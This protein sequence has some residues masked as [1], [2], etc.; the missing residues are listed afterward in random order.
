MTGFDP[1][2]M[3]EG[4]A[5][6]TE[7]ILEL[8][9]M[10]RAAALAKL[11]TLVE[12]KVGPGPRLWAVRIDPARP[13]GGETLFQPV[14]RYLLQAKRAGKVLAVTPLADPPGGGFAVDLGP[15]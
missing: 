14:G 4:A 15:Q 1:I 11:R 10:S 7:A 8:R 9:G 3:L 13:G 2:A 5:F 6:E 12:I